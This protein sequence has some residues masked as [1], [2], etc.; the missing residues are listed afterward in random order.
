[1]SA[2]DKTKRLTRIIYVFYAMAS[3]DIPNLL[4]FP[5]RPLGYDLYGMFACTVEALKLRTLDI[6]APAACE[7]SVQGSDKLIVDINIGGTARLCVLLI[8][9]CR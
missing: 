2:A 9:K 1:M 6:V 4:A 8:K 5:S 3:A 7:I